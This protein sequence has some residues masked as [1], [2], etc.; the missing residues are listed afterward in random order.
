MSSEI[1]PREFD[2]SEH[3][4]RC[5]MDMNNTYECMLCEDSKWQYNVLKAALG[6]TTEWSHPMDAINPKVS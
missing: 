3:S 2:I 1:S 4:G 6:F 5:H